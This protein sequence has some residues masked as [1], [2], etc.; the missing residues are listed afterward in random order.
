M[1]YIA[2]K[3]KMATIYHMALL[4]ALVLAT[5]L[6]FRKYGL[7]MRFKRINLGTLHTSEIT[8]LEYKPLFSAKLFYF[9][10]GDAQEIYHNHSFA[11]YSFLF[12]GNYFERF[13]DPKTGCEWEL[14]RNRSRIIYI[15]K[16]KFHQITKSQ[17][18]MTLMVTGPWGDTYEE[19][20]V[21]KREIIVSTHGRREVRREVLGS[22]S[23]ATSGQR[24]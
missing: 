1:I 23:N 6:F 13:V 12:Y 14:P 20:N 10:P 8:I 24:N 3:I 16:K 11:A 15:G 4:A 7:I 18:C 22:G 19:Y 9:H 2:A 5:F 21:A 17:G